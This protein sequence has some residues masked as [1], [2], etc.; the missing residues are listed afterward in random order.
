M[1]TSAKA[2]G[3]AILAALAVLVLAGAPATAGDITGYVYTPFGAPFAEM[4]IAAAQTGN[5]GGYGLA[6]SWAAAPVGWYSVTGLSSGTYSMGFGEKDEWYRYMLWGVSVGSGSTA[7]SRR[8]DYPNYVT[9][10]Y[11]DGVRV[12]YWAQS[13][14]ATGTSVISASIDC[15]LE[16]GPNTTIAIH[17]TDPW[18]AQIGPARTVPTNIANPSAAHWC[19]G[20]VPTIPGHLYCAKF[21]ATDGIMPFI[22]TVKVRNSNAYP[23]GQ[24]WRNGVVSLNPLKTVIGQDCDGIVTTVS[25]RKVSPTSYVS[26]TVLG[27]TFT[28]NGSSVL[29]VNVLAGS[30]AGVLK[31]S[32]HDGVGTGG[33]G[34]TQ[35]GPTKYVKVDN[36]N[37]R[38]MAVWAPGEA[39]PLT[40]GRAYYVKMVRPDGS[41]F[42]L[43]HSNTDE[44]SGGA[45]YATGSAQAFDLS[46]TIAEE[47]YSGSTAVQTVGITGPLVTR[48]SDSATIAWTSSVAATES[49]VDFGLTTPYSYRKYDYGSTSHSVTLTGL[50]PNTLYH[51]RVVS[52]A[53]GLRDG[54][55]RDF[56][57]VTEPVGTNLLVNPGFETGSMSPWNQIA[58]TFGV[59]SGDHFGCTPHSGTYF[60][61]GA[62]NG[63]Q[64]KG[65][66]YQRVAVAPNR[67]LK[68]R[69]WIWTWQQDQ[70]GATKPYTACGRIGIDPTGGTNVNSTSI[71][72]SPLVAAQ[73]LFGNQAGAWTEVWTTASP[74]GS[75]AT[76]F[77]QSGA[78]QAMAWTVVGHDDAVL[79]QEPTTTA[80]TKLSQLKTMGDGAKVS[81]A[82]KVV[83]ATEDQ[84]GANYV[85]EADRTAGIRVES[86]DTFQIGHQVSVTGY[87]GTKSNGER[88]IY[89]ATKTA[90]SAAQEIDSMATRLANIGA[91]SPSN[92]GLLM[93]V[94]GRV[95]S[96]GS[97]HF[98]INDGS[99]P[100]S[101]L[102]MQAGNIATLP[103]VGQF[104]AVTGVVHLRGTTI[105]GQIVVH[106]RSQ[107]DVQAVH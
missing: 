22:S 97:N 77:I 68:A 50:T 20:Q 71:V 53:A 89:G 72:W 38:C 2:A 7:L 46:I 99:M 107:S 19:A 5:L 12:P 27:Q 74:T 16:F 41:A 24:T 83:I 15:A 10:K 8:I 44:Y 6:W 25:T 67:P 13:F 59:V 18:G 66:C 60:Q 9:G 104:V 84:I 103:A 21:S 88:Y 82:S 31:C 102:R 95:T 63:G 75:Y 93:R 52:K 90:D 3:A 47:A 33:Q 43:Y 35:I 40:A 51:A 37:H 29:Y 61:N 94:A 106:P 78:D 85:E 34:G 32:I 96:V 87:L 11:W 48:Y 1:T 23:D 30:T 65:G 98:F 101:G 70:I 28:A 91:V 36:W 80:V 79:T 81:F 56:V 17:D 76:V 39:G 26:G 62:S 100:G 54:V 105:P 49:Y 57:F 45:A 92:M 55:S 4:P 42:A 73:D 64:I 14:V 86:L 58:G 69:A